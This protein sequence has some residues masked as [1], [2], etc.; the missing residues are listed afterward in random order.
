M[1]LSSFFTMPSLIWFNSCLF[2][3]QTG[4][5]DRSQDIMMQIDHR[6]LRECESLYTPEKLVRHHHP[7][8]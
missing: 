5:V 1:S 3:S 7:K 2:Y 8:T 4:A 6:R